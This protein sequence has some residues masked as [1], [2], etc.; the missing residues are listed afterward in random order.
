MD[1]RCDGPGAKDYTGFILQRTKAEGLA[2]TFS[3]T[4]WVDQVANTVATSAMIAILPVAALM[5]LVHPF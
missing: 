2:M 4:K 3:F 5:L 1:G